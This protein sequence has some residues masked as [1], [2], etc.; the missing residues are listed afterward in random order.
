MSLSTNSATALK[1]LTDNIL[2]F[3]IERM[4]DPRGGFYGRIDGQGKLI[5]DAPKGAVLNARLL[6]TFSA[7]Y[8]VL[9]RPEYLE[10]ASRAKDEII[11]RFY[12]PDFGGVYWSLN[13]DGSPL[14]TKK[15]GYAIGFA[16]YGL[17]EYYRACGDAQSLDYAF[18]LFHSLE[19]HCYDLQK[20][21]YAEAFT[22][23]W[24]A[25][26][27]MRLS[28]KDENERFTMNTHLHILEPYTNLLRC[29]RDPLLEKQHAGLIRIF[30]EHILEPSGH[31]GL[32]FDDDWNSTHDYISYGH[33]IEAS[34]LLQEAAEVLGNEGLLK[35][36]RQ[37]AE[38]IALAAAEGWK[39]GEGMIYEYKR[40]SG[41]LDEDR[42]WW[43][44]AE[45]VVGF[46]YMYR[47]NGR[48]EWLDKASDIL[49][50]ICRNL[51]D[52]EGEWFWSIRKDGSI[53]RDDDKA[54]FWKCPYHNSRMCL[55][56]Q[57]IKNQ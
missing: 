25:I 31:L 50:F 12:D 20:G 24:G 2:P 47:L 5:P 44:Q 37:A 52:P 27:D 10:M 21:G 46:S 38:R 22:R 19:E 56:L 53:N 18:R 15:Q 3:W 8:R 34:W 55:E 35:E 57:D 49:D 23:E 33:D 28:D 54:G 4:A 42:H 51:V 40:E 43:V 7:A 39:P 13:A 17:S 1:L 32:F 41:E 14:D 11:G 26:A 6:W 48:Q 30:L 45:S 16:I 29:R 9:G 36:A